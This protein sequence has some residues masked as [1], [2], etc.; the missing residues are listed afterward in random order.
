MPPEP[1]TA[2]PLPGWASAAHDPARGDHDVEP[3]TAPI[4]GWQTSNGAVLCSTCCPKPAGAIPV[5]LAGEGEG[6]RW[7]E[8]PTELCADTTAVGGGPAAGGTH[9]EVGVE[10]EVDPAESDDETLFPEDF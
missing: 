8:S 10:V 5:T 4:R 3:A 6:L 7:E 1:T 9:V 2:P